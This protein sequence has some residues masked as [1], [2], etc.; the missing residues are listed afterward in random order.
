MFGASSMQD[1]ELGEYSPSHSSSS[2]QV[3]CSHELCEMGPTCKTPKGNCPYTVNYFSEDT[4]SSGFLFEDM[5]HLGSVGGNQ[6]QSSVQAKII[7]GY[8]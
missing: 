8:V 2:K 7:L 3:P 1:K 5:M 4:S 6:Q